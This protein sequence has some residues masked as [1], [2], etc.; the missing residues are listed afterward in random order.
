M[1]TSTPTPT[2]PRAG[3]G[4]NAN[5]NA[6]GNAAPKTDLSAYD[7][8]QVAM[9]QEEII[10]V[11]ANDKPVR[12][13]TKKE[14][15]VNDGTDNILLHRAFS[16][17]MFDES[18]RLLM[19]KRSPDKITFP[20]YWAN[21]CCSHPTFIPEELEDGVGVKRAAVRKLEQELGI[22]RAQVPL[23]EL[24]YLTTI[25]YLAG[26]E[27]GWG[28]H[29]IDHI[30]CTRVDSRKLTL[31]PNP[32]EVAEARWFT[33]PELAALLADPK[34]KVSPWFRMLHAKFLPGWWAELRQHGSLDA[35]VRRA[36]REIHRLKL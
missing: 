11:D 9:M 18:G 28:E 35:S 3:A 33:E 1:A 27:N 19:Q 15:H 7:P 5:A 8:T 23:T 14:C 10:V 12:A 21:T 26:G 2:T 16:V 31:Q 25:H 4:A 24:K 32:N 34:V 36:T 6:K 30:L 29:E 17:F 20:E 13:G 22:P